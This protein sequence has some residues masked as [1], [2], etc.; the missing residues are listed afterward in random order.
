LT[1]IKLVVQMPNSLAIHQPIRI[2]HEPSFG[3]KVDSWS[4]AL[5][6]IHNSHF[7]IHWKLASKH[8]RGLYTSA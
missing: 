6:L 8:L 1:V 7:S 3:C 2:V 4:L 5:V